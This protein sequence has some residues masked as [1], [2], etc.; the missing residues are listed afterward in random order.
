MV[1]FIY[2][3]N[4]NFWLYSQHF[5]SFPEVIFLTFFYEKNKIFLPDEKTTCSLEKK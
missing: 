5:K 1:K 2:L 3:P 4:I